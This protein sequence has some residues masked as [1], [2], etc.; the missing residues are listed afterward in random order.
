MTIFFVSG[1]HFSKSGSV[2][3]VY[4]PSHSV[5]HTLTDIKNI[6]CAKL[7]KLQ[8]CWVYW[9]RPNVYLFLMR[10]IRHSLTEITVYF[11]GALAKLRKGTISF[12]TPVCLSV[13]PHRTTWLPLYG[14]SWNLVFEY[15]SKICRENSRVI[16][17]WQE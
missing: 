16:K 17:I 11:L 7:W 13:R 2:R 4:W 5:S 3:H 14:F 9:A 12:V 1:S 15:F 8:M 6:F 10:C